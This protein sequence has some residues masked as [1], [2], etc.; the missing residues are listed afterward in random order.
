MPGQIA[1]NI[2]VGLIR[3][4]REKLMKN[5]SAAA[6]SRRPRGKAEVAERQGQLTWMDDQTNPRLPPRIV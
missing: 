6:L 4:D 1:V 2:V 3:A 5:L